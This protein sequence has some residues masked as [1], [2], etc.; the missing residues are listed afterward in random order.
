MHAV[1]FCALALLCVGVISAQSDGSS[2]VALAYKLLTAKDYDG[3]IAAFGRGLK[4]QPKAGNIHKDLAYTLLKAGESVAAR[5]EFKAALDLDPHDETSALEYAFL[6]YETKREVEAR[7][8]F[9]RLRQYGV[10]PSTRDTASKAFE[11]IDQPLAEGIDR[12]KKSIAKLSN[13][14]DVSSFSA[15]W[16]LAQLAEHRDNLPLASEQYEICRKLKP[17]LPSLLIDL[18]RVW[19]QMNEVEQA[20]AALLAAS[21]GADPRTAENALELLG[22]RYPYAY[23][24]QNAIQLDPRNIALRRELAYLYLA[25][26]KEPE[27]IQEFQKLLKIAPG[28]KLSLAQLDALR[29]AA[30][31]PAPTLPAN[32]SDLRIDPKAMGLKS[33]AAGY[34]ND[35]IRYL[36]IAHENDPDDAEVMLQLGWAYN[37]AKNDIEAIHWFEAAR[38]STNR[39]IARDADRAW[40]NLL[41]SNPAQTTMWLLPMYSSRWN[42]NFVYGQVKRNLPFGARLPIHFYLSGRFIGDVRGQVTLQP[43]RPQLNGSLPG[44][45]SENAIIPG[46]GASSRQWHHLLGWAE[47]GLSI[48]YLPGRRDVGAAI[49]DYRGGLNFARGFGSLLGNARPGLFYETSADA[50]YVSR[51]DKDWLFY[52]QHRLGRTFHAFGGDYFQAYLNGN[53]VQDVKR[54]FWA[55]SV[56]FGPGG[57]VHLPGTRPGVY[58]SA[59]WLRGAYTMHVNDDFH[60]PNYNDFRLGFW[61]AAAR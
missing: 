39:S 1:R 31:N 51:F 40:H 59:D 12:W 21:R 2:D 32:R 27:A 57:R 13:P 25:L 36:R 20:H 5:D 34:T 60:R 19:Q 42:D 10:A 46:I 48:S 44:Y 26:G 15:H 7:R 35:A 4:L 30:K 24:F 54:E 17:D 50:V 18:A 29:P 3:A 16:E 49:P 22:P 56:E 8:V 47:A 14:L 28:D 33:L 58:L 38:H 55:N 43:V 45:L 61:Y 37:L 23:E 52:S 53:V 9:G 11:S 41:G 6:C